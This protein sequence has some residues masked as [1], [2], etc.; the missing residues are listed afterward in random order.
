MTARREDIA[1]LPNWPRLLSKA[2]AAAYVGLSEPAFTYRVGK[3]LPS[4]CNIGNRK[5]W[6]R[7]EIDDAIDR[8]TGIDAPS[9]EKLLG[10]L[11]GESEKGDSETH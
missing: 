9:S 5:L 7:R 6:D 2:Q 3:E 1:D 4:A 11:F 8:L 10:R